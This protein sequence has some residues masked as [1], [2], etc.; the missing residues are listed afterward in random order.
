ML[1][2]FSEAGG[3]SP[4]AFPPPVCKWDNYAMRLRGNK[5]AKARAFNRNHLIRQVGNSTFNVLPLKGN[6]QVHTVWWDGD[7]QC[8]CQNNRIN[9]DI[10]SHILAVNLYLK[11]HG[12]ENDEKGQEYEG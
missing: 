5:L 7:W 1:T 4:T 2:T 8:S 11:I 12:G 6:H 9:F 10:C 3:G